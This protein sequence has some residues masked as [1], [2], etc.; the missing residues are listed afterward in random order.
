MVTPHALRGFHTDGSAV[1]RC[2]GAPEWPSPTLQIVEQDRHVND[3]ID[4]E[5]VLT[6]VRHA[7]AQR[8]RASSASRGPLEREVRCRFRN[9]CPDYLRVNLYVPDGMP[10]MTRS[11][12]YSPGLVQAAPH[13]ARRQDHCSITAWVAGLTGLGLAASRRRWHD[14]QRSWDRSPI[15][16]FCQL[17]PITETCLVIVGPAPY[18]AQHKDVIAH[19]RAGVA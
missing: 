12:A 10:S 3:A 2:S 1:R 11:S 18:S 19:L 8:P 13:G 4:L 6:S 7:H 9:K 17:S 5:H 16:A 14:R 15:R